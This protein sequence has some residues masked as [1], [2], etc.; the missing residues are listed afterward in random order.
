[1]NVVKHA[2]IEVLDHDFEGLMAADP[3]VDAVG[4]VL[5]EK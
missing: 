5:A 2:A 4:L 1:V 3:V